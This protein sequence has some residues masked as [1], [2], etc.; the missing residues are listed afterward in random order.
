MSTPNIW[1]IIDDGD[2]F[3]GTAEQYLDCFGDTGGFTQ[4]ALMEYWNNLPTCED[5]V[6]EPSKIIII[7]EESIA[8]I[9]KHCQEG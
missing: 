6:W 1:I 7:S 2:S 8:L 9:L 3:E 4:K 5:L